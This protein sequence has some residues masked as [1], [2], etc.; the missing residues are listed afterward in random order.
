MTQAY[1]SQPLV[2]DLIPLRPPEVESALFALESASTDIYPENQ[3][4]L[5]LPGELSQMLVKLENRGTRPLQL[6][7]ELTGDFPS[8]WCQI[9]TE[10]SLLAPGDRIE[11]VLS[12]QIPPDFFEAPQALG[13]GQV[14]KLDYSGR[15]DVYGSY[16]G[17]VPQL[18]E[19]T[20][21]NLSVRPITRYLDFLPQIYREIDFVGRFLQIFEA[22]FEPDVQILANL[23]AYLDPLTAPKGMLDFLAYWVGWRMQPYV[24]LERQ[25]Y[26]IRNALE[27]YR[28]RG[29]RRGLRL[30]LHLATNLPLDEHLENEDD[31]H[32]GIYEFFSRGFVLGETRL[33]HDAFLG[34]VR[35]FHFTVYLRPEADYPVDE[36]LVRT[37]IEQAKPAFCSYELFLQPRFTA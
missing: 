11:A 2:L 35:P 6:N 34:G 17:T 16:P 31:K 37:A 32:I 24:S 22:T 26:L 4:L 13:A 36:Q 27:I 10:G 1:F 29:T 25:R 18:L 23:W 19:V 12:F 7:L 28:W 9:G 3:T 14:L 33:G 8:G 21:F 20:N 30:H 15:L 5:L